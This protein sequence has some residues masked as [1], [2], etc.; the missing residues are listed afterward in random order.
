M[1]ARFAGA[2]HPAPSAGTVR[3][4]S[5]LQ[6]Q[7]AAEHADDVFWPHTI[8]RRSCC[9][10]PVQRP[11]TSSPR[12]GARRRCR[13]QQERIFLAEGTRQPRLAPIMPT[14][15]AR[16]TG[17]PKS[18]QCAPEPIH[19]RAFPPLSAAQ[20]GAARRAPTSRCL[21]RVLP[22]HP[23]ARCGMRTRTREHERAWAHVPNAAR[24]APRCRR[25][26][27]LARG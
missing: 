8:S 7:S 4:K 17:L 12:R 22:L 15:C 5:I 19:G 27:R 9:R 20:A 13:F 14:R 24:T 1:S 16:V 23:T 2:R 26:A 25:A 6:T 21:S 10:A 11:T 18:R 3:L